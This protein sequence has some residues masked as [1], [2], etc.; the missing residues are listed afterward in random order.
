[1]PVPVITQTRSPSVTGDGDDRFC[2]RR[3]RLPAL[4]CRFQSTSP[5]LRSMHQSSRLSSSTATLRKIRSFQTIGVEPDRRGTA[6]F[7]ATLRSVSHSSGR[8]VSALTPSAVGPR[9]WG[10]F[11]AAAGPA[12]RALPI[13]AAAKAETRRG[14][15]M[16]MYM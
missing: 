5:V 3:R 13:S 12:V 14:R 4:R 2:L 9:Q 15:C 16:A 7:Q 8:S 10:Q 11:P 1:M 6:S